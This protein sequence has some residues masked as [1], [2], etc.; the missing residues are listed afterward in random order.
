M[1]KYQILKDALGLRDRFR[2]QGKTVVL[3]NGCFDILHGGHIHLFKQAKKL[4]DVLIVAIN[5]DASI[6][7]LKGPSRPIF[8][9][10]ERLEVLAAVG[11]IDYLVSFSQDTP[12]ELIAALVPDV[13]VKGGDWA[14]GE[15]VGRDEVEGAG[16]RVVVIPYL[17][18][19]SST[20]I[21]NKI[22][23]LK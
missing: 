10:E 8:P 5:E 11:Y 17:P 20:E 23:A 13:L 7:R 2:K 1:D 12:Q 14:L 18:G 15:V 3:T 21:I 4:G 6:Q 16:G 22:R 19:Y 9:L